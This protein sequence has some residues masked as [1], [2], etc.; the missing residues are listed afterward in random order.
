MDALRGNDLVRARSTFH[1][2]GGIRQRQKM[3]ADGSVPHSAKRDRSPVSSR[4]FVAA[5][6]EQSGGIALSEAEAHVAVRTC[7]P[8]AQIPTWRFM[9]TQSA[10]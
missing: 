7:L 10:P 9:P 2:A 5:Q 6:Y 3:F 8:I 1:S 4:D